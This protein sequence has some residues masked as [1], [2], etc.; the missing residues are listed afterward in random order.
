MALP[1]SSI[2]FLDPALLV[3]ALSRAR[4]DPESL[5]AR[6]KARLPLFKGKTYHP[7]DAPHVPHVDAE[8]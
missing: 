4:T 1:F 7:P 6:V 5:A 8:V 3:A 2:G